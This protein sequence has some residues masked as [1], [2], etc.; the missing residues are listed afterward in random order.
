MAANEMAWNDYIKITKDTDHTMWG[1]T[2][3]RLKKSKEG[4]QWPCPSE[5]H[6][7]TYK[8][9]VRGMDPMFEHQ[10]FIEKFGKKCRKIVRSC[11]YMDGKNEGRAN[12]FLRPIREPKKC[13][14]PTTPFYLDYRTG[15]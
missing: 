7:G 2:Y 3:E 13:R 9:Y 15:H 10:G 8:R 1:M 6:P 12:I 5:D 11:F 14:V 4:I